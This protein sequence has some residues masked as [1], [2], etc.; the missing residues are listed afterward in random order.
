MV[1]KISLFPG[2]LSFPDIPYA[3]TVIGLRYEQNNSSRVNSGL[4]LL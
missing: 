1:I 3:L 2:E 4:N